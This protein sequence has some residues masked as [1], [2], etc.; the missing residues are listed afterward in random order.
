MPH[1]IRISASD[2]N[3]NDQ[4]IQ[5]VTDGH[6]SYTSSLGASTGVSVALSCW[7]VKQTSGNVGDTG[8]DDVL[9]H[10]DSPCCSSSIL[11]TVD[12]EASMPQV[13][14]IPTMLIVHSTQFT[15]LS[16]FTTIQLARSSTTLLCTIFFLVTQ[17]IHNSLSGA[18]DDICN[19]FHRGITS[20]LFLV[21]GFSMVYISAICVFLL[22]RYVD[23]YI[24]SCHPRQRDHS[25]VKTLQLS[26]IF[27]IV[28]T[29]NICVIVGPFGILVISLLLN[30]NLGT[31]SIPIPLG[32]AY[33]P[34][35]SGEF[36]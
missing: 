25:Y 3:N 5:Q 31:Y 9:R 11:C 33:A 29:L 34:E 30:I 23:R 8:L 10:L 20:K 24:R 21:I 19:P 16:F 1:F 13:L 28:G 12:S 36:P 7:N 35:G 2:E 17:E 27:G 26:R 14:R 6:Y 22:D 4:C 32:S 18:P 15:K